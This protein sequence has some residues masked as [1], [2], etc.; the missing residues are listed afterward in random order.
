MS[1]NSQ[2]NPRAILVQLHDWPGKSGPDGATEHPALR[3]MLD[4][5]A[6]AECLVEDENLSPEC[7][8]AMVLFSALHDLGKINNEFREMIRNGAKP[9]FRHWEVTEAHLIASEHRIASSLDVIDFEEDSEALRQLFAATAGHHGKPPILQP[10]LGNLD[11]GRNEYFRR[12]R[13]M[14]RC[15][16]NQACDDA[17]TL[18]EAF[19]S[20]WPKSSLN[21]LT[22]DEAKRLSWRFAG[23]I[24]V[25]DWIGSNELWFP[26]QPGVGHLGDYLDDARKRAKTAVYESGLSAARPRKSD[27]KLFDF[28]LRPM[29]IAARDTELREGPMLV[30]IEDETGAG[31][32][33][34]AL[35][36]AD[37]M[38]RAGK[39]GGLFFALPTMATSEAMFERLQDMLR[40]L[41]DGHPSLALANSRAKI[42]EAFRLLVRQSASAETTDE[43]GCTQWLADDRRR[44][45]LADLGVGTIDQALMGVLPTKHFALRLWGVSHKILIVDEAHEY[46]PYMAKEIEELLYAHARQNGSAI[47][48]TATLPIEMRR[49]FVAAFERGTGRKIT[50]ETDRSY[51][52]LRVIGRGPITKRAHDRLRPRIE[53]RPVLS[54]AA[55]LETVLKAVEKGAA[56]AWV[57]NAV[58]DAR[59]AQ[60]KLQEAGACC[61]LLHAR[62]ALCDR[63][64]Q[65]S[66]ALA[67]YGKCRESRVGRILVGTQVLESSLDLDF[68]VMIT[69][70][71]PMASVIQRVGR[72]WRHMDLRPKD[73][74]PIANPVLHVLTP[75]PNL[76]DDQKW[77]HGTLDAG[78]WVYPQSL[79]WL[80]A[81]RLFDTESI[82]APDDLRD[83][84]ESVHGEETR[85]LPEAL[86]SN[87][88][89]NEGD[90]LAR[91]TLAGY[92]VVDFDAGYSGAQK[93]WDDAE[94]PTRLGRPQCT[95]VLARILDAKLVPWGGGDFNNPKALM[96]SE[97]RAHAARISRL[98]LPD[99][100]DQRIAMITSDW[101]EWRR[102]TTRICPVG[103]DGWICQGLRYDRKCGLM[104]DDA[105][106]KGVTHEPD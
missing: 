51:P 83:L 69:D 41:F 27:S 57:R 87:A 104:F 58:D 71:A 94:Y 101:P 49:R 4:V 62:F 86:K 12:L 65:E 14:R 39:G 72:L 28:A 96:L 80:T 18:I 24:T 25:A 17:C 91:R 32:T 55:A 23:L 13:R 89:E 31:K 99:Q 79:L 103:E 9:S 73:M 8:E 59:V 2:T 48:M 46:D 63:L 82:L 77:V 66:F 74:R 88:L 61:D 21:G 11:S 43:P 81:R 7:R 15:A 98:P 26:H 50:E 53:V 68:D 16:G 22:L 100:T 20:L 6:V 67:T 5:A 29:Q 37:R 93:I 36:L 95:L 106:N 97:V 70:I 78:A 3:H 38:M 40:K 76:V 42:S 64:E 54:E 56:V 33:E 47:L 105:M 19:L 85:P 30:I 75:D 34:A 44:A 45:L 92:N 35:I 90:D 1:D 60:E 52:A 102:A 10:A 84:I